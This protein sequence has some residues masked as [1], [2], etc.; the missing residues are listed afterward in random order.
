MPPV[1]KMTHQPTDTVDDYCLHYGY[2]GPALYSAVVKLRQ[3]TTTSASSAQSAIVTGL[4]SRSH[5]LTF[6]QVTQYY[7]FSV[8]QR[9]LDN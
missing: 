6:P 8:Q 7:Y 4:T 3:T 9:L 2:L 1:L 5:P